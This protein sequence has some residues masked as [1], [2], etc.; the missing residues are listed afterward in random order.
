MPVKKVVVFSMRG[1]RALAVQPHREAWVEL[2]LAA[3][4]HNARLL[5][6]HIPAHVALMAILKADAYGHGAALVLPVLEAAGFSRVGVASVDEALQLREGGVKLPILLLSGVPGWAI[7]LA[8]QH[9]LSLSVFNTSQL[10]AIEQAYQQTQTPVHFHVK[11]DT[12]MHRVGVPWEEASCFFKACM[13]FKPMGFWDG[14]FTHLA[15]AESWE[16]S[17]TQWQR[18]QTVLQSLPPP[19]QG[20]PYWRHSNS[21][22]LLS[23]PASSW[24]SSNL[25][26]VG[27]A[28]FGYGDLPQLR[29]VMGLK[30]RI[31]HL[32]HVPAGE[33]I[34]YGHRYQ[35][36]KPSV[37][38]TLP[39]G[40]AD[41]VPRGLSNKLKAWVLGMTVPQVGTI[42]M[43]Q[44]M[45]DVSDVPNVALGETVVLLDTSHQASQ[46]GQTLIH[47]AQALNTIEYELM[48][49][50]RVRLPRVYTRS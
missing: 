50:L 7:P 19:Q 38:A 1:S 17:Q 23:L 24:H 39:L 30:A 45:L 37:I 46:G 20:G 16:Q 27:L 33:G 21:A 49:G 36:N 11:V 14:V 6:Q 2:D 41:G 3:L 18:W 34:S 9:R 26:R 48:C 25:A 5:R 42:T 43:D 32:Q 47:W 12:G 28:L 31:T 10:Q 4:E 15:C 22:G 29:P 8:M 13:A 44:L 35:T 40:Y